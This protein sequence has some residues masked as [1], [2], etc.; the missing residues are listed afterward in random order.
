[1]NRL[2]HKDPIAVEGIDNALKVARALLEAGQQVFVQ[3]DDCDIYIVDYAS[4]DDGLYMPRF[5][6][7]TVEEEETILDARRG[8]EEE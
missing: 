4:N 8:G 1:M 7:I 5:G 2:T 3:L 6:L